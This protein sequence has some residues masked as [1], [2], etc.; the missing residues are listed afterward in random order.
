MPVVKR[1][2]VGRKGKGPDGQGKTREVKLGCVFTQTTVDEKGRPVRDEA[3]TTYTGIVETASEFSPRIYGEAVRRGISG[4]LRV[5]V[6]GDGGTWIWNIADEQF[7][8]AV[9]IIDLYHAREHYW[10]VARAVFGD[11]TISMD[12]WARKRKKELNGGKPEKVIRAIRE[13]TP[14]SA[15]SRE[16]CRTE[17]GY[18]ENNRGRMKYDEYRKGNLFVGSGVIEA[19]CKSVIG[20]RLKLSGMH[21]TVRGANSI[22]SLRCCLLSNRWEDFWEFRAAA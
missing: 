19:G 13:L 21:W 6:L 18:F 12:A 8:G 9:Q 1:E 3:S 17:I 4:A 11:D 7:P 2:T 14:A 20:Q 16:V 15:H 10:K 5:V 22:I